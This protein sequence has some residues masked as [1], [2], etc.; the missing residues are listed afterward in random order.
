MSI[1]V[2]YEEPPAGIEPALRP[3]EGRILSIELQ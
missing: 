2:S 1:T 3:S